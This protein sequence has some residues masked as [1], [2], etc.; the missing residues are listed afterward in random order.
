MN[1]S[2]CILCLIMIILSCALILF[3]CEGKPEDPTPA[4]VL[5]EEKPEFVVEDYKT[6]CE[7]IVL[8]ETLHFDNWC[9]EEMIYSYHYVEKE[10]KEDETY[11]AKIDGNWYLCEK[12]PFDYWTK[13]LTE[14]PYDDEV[15]IKP[16]DFYLDS[17]GYYALKTKKTEYYTHMFLEFDDVDISS[18]R[19]K[20]NNDEI[21]VEM[22]FSI[23]FSEIDTH[24]DGKMT[25]LYNTSE[26][27]TLPEKFVPSYNIKIRGITT[28][29]PQSIFHCWVIENV[30]YSFS[31]E[32]ADGPH[33]NPGIEIDAYGAMVTASWYN[34][35]WQYYHNGTEPQS[36]GFMMIRAMEQIDFADFTEEGESLVLVSSKLNAYAPIILSNANPDTRVLSEFKI[37]VFEGKIIEMVYSSFFREG[38]EETETITTTLTFEYDTLK[39]E[40]LP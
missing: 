14:N 4:I 1:K 29:S 6:E 25:F 27:F 32:S 36:I 33:F 9:S 13:S 26:T 11:Y 5:P 17:D 21:P 38:L 10:T 39:Y 24:A 7:V 2:P 19:V 15:D 16:E 30:A 3:A 20:F 8:G 23:Y 31:T 35:Q 34:N 12:N 28:Y 22:L 40:D 18:L 37:K